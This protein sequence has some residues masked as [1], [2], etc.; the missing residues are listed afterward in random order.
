MVQNQ[1]LQDAIRAIDQEILRLKETIR[2]LRSERNGIVPISQLPPELLARIFQF[3]ADNEIHESNPMERINFSYVSH[4]WRDVALNTSNLWRVISLGFPNCSTVMLQRSKMADLIL[5][6]GGDLET[7]KHTQII[8]LALSHI[9][10]VC[11]I[12]IRFSGSRAD[13]PIHEMLRQ[14]PKSAPRLRSLSVTPI[15]PNSTLYNMS[16]PTIFPLTNTPYLRRL[17]LTRCNFLNWDSELLTGL[18]YLKVHRISGRHDPSTDQVL[19]ALR[20]LP[21]LSHLDLASVS[22][23]PGSTYRGDPVNLP[24]LKDLR[25]AGLLNDISFILAHVVINPSASIEIDCV[26]RRESRFGVAQPDVPGFF[27]SLSSFRNAYKARPKPTYVNLKTFHYTDGHIHLNVMTYT[28]DTSDLDFRKRSDRPQFSLNLSLDDRDVART[29]ARAD[30]LGY[31]FQRVLPLEQDTSLRTL[32][33]WSSGF[34]ASNIIADAFGRLPNLERV[35]LAVAERT[36]FINALMHKPSNYNSSLDAWG[37]VILPRLRTLAFG[38]YP[39]RSGHEV[40]A[41]Q[42]CLI[43]RCERNAPLQKLIAKLGWDMNDED[44]ALLREIVVDLEVKPSFA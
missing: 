7:S 36:Q 27:S 33:W 31:M 24:E 3:I 4:H 11:E 25:L 15:N 2:R 30:Q 12:I 10:R 34:V 42:D 43:E 9:E 37:S 8:Q 14:F 1:P 20:R 38:D 6:A 41:L 29:V 5:Y 13:G 16:L 44:E 39:L 17:V 19:N 32:V 23:T 22:V 18:T 26:D 35:G 21:T 28:T 40:W